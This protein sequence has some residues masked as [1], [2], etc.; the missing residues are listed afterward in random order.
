MVTTIDHYKKQYF[1]CGCL[2]RTQNGEW[3]W[4]KS[5]EDGVATLEPMT[6]VDIDHFASIIEGC[7]NPNSNF[8][9]ELKKAFEL[10]ERLKK[11]RFKFGGITISVKRKTANSKTIKS[12]WEEKN[13]KI[14]DRISYFM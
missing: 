3:F 9:T 8:E 6:A 12:N 14:S 1:A 7:F 11:I 2:F 5:F 4:V 13:L 10:K